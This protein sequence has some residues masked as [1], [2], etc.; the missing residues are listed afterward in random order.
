M[1][2]LGSSIS[3]SKHKKI[4]NTLRSYNI[5]T[6]FHENLPLPFI[7]IFIQFCTAELN[8]L[9]GETDNCFLKRKKIFVF[10]E[11]FEW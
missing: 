10:T 4:K 11:Y 2:V 8:I 7:V 5:N 1:C 3:G 9:C 6:F